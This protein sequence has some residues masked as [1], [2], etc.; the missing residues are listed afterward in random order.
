MGISFSVSITKFNHEFEET[1]K[2][3]TNTK[4]NKLCVTLVIQYFDRYFA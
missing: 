3:L 4:K 2:N 1:G